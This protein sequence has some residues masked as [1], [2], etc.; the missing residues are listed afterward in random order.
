MRKKY[1][2]MKKL[3][4]TLSLLL[5]LSFTQAQST[6]PYLVAPGAGITTVNTVGIVSSDLLVISDNEIYNAINSQA[7]GGANIR[8]EFNKYLNGTWTNLADITTT[9]NVGRTILRKAKN[10]NDIY[11]AYSHQDANFVKYVTVKKFDGTSWTSLGTEQEWGHIYFDF[12]LD[13]NDVP[14]L[15]GKK[16]TSFQFMKIMKW[17]SNAW[18][19]IELTGYLDLKF[20]RGSSYVDANNNLVFLKNS[21]KTRLGVD[22]GAVD[23]DTLIG[24]S[25]TTHFED[26]RTT[27][28]SEAFFLLDSNGNQMFFTQTKA[29]GTG[30]RLA[31][32]KKTAGTWGLDKTDTSNFN[33]VRNVAI[34]NT[35]VILFAGVEYGATT[36]TMYDYSNLSSPVYSSPVSSEINH[37]RFTKNKVYAL[38]KNGVV[39]AD[40]LNL[41]GI[42]SKKEI[43]VNMFPNPVNSTLTIQN[44]ASS[45][46]AKIE[47]YSIK[48]ELMQVESNTTT[49]NVENLSKGMYILLL[50]AKDGSVGRTK[51]IK[52]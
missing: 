7:G 10:S 22:Y 48:A 12:Q 31:L 26:I 20:F 4:I 14:I 38:I 6:W 52:E 29:S 41:T 50:E 45:D 9:H 11:V 19:E 16:S 13:N 18:T 1:Q 24:D 17:Q 46:V 49:V 34:A 47:I 28:Y 36:G 30:S 35:G 15:L 42:N 3:Y 44:I 25:V 23:I 40:V 51:F 27:P 37:I 43:A 2:D 33:L 21:V 32:H 5:S 8:L 39:T